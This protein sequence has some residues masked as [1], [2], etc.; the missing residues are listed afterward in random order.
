MAKVVEVVTP[1]R[2]E[3]ATDDC[4]DVQAR[5]H[6]TQKRP[7]DIDL[8]MAYDGEETDAWTLSRE[9]VDKAAHEPR[10]EAGEGDV[11]IKTFCSQFI[12]LLHPPGCHPATVFLNRLSVR[13]FMDN[14]NNMM[15]WEDSVQAVLYQLDEWLKES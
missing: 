12:L 1:C 8:I 3:V 9:M 13:D 15:S 4:L 11:T 7:Y 14:V 10:S 6:F 5:L 2:L